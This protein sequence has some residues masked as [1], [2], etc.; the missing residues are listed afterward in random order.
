MSIIN[1]DEINPDV[2]EDPSIISLKNLIDKIP[3][4]P[5]RNE[6][7]SSFLNTLNQFS[8]KEA[9]P[10]KPVNSKTLDF[11]RDDEI[12]NSISSRQFANMTHII[13]KEK[14]EKVI[15]VKKEEK[16]NTNF[17]YDMLRANNIKKRISDNMKISSNESIKKIK[18]TKSSTT[19][20]NNTTKRSTK[21]R[22]SCCFCFK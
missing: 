16:K 4:A 22:I 20:T 17:V 10:N 8:T 7:R 13:D 1:P 5:S 3:H 12:S 14:Y 2:S 19:S 6:R 21:E 15:N 11:I 9:T 18:K